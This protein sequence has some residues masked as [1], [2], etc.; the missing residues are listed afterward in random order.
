MTATDLGD[1]ANEI[2][3]AF[4]RESRLDLQVRCPLGLRRHI[5]AP[6]LKTELL[7][8]LRRA[9]PVASQATLL[10]S[11]T[12]GQVR[13]VVKS[14]AGTEVLVPGGVRQVQF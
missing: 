13:F 12:N 5:S 7:A 1:L 8:A 6:R 9:G 10:V 2:G 11:Q 3:V 4:A 14:E